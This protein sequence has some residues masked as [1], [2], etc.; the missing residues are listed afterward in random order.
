M[1][2]GAILN[3]ETDISNLLPLDGSKAM[4]GALAM[5]N[6]KITGLS[7][8]TASTDAATYGQLT[9][10]S[11]AASRITGTL[12]TSNIPNLNASKITSGTFATARIPNLAASKITSGIL[13]VARGGTGVDNLEDLHN[14]LDTL[15][16]IS[17]SHT[18]SYTNYEQIVS[19]TDNLMM[20]PRKLPYMMTIYGDLVSSTRTHRL[21]Y[22]VNSN[23]AWQ[24]I[25]FKCGWRT[26]LSCR[27]SWKD[28]GSLAL[29]IADSISI[30]NIEYN[31][32]NG[33]INLPEPL[34]IN[35]SDDITTE[36]R[37]YYL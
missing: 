36:I 16:Y 14:E 37:F 33:T 27:W 17:F 15:N 10:V 19:T 6:H 1:A 3:K 20:K 28:N 12:S 8:G 13:P 11:I 18:Q 21:A 35:S 24:I 31:Y 30:P 4:T 2:H 22:R 7:N 9:S 25:Y 34:C 23:S 29:V 26:P 32:N 5:G